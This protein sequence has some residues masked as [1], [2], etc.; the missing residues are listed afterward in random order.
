MESVTIKKGSLRFQN[1]LQQLQQVLLTAG[2]TANPALSVYQQKGRNILFMLEALGRIYQEIHNKKTFEKLTNKFKKLE[3]LLGEIDYYDSFYNQFSLVKSVPTPILE[4]IQT[5]RNAAIEKLNIRLAEKEWI[6][7]KQKQIQK[8]NAKLNSA[9]WLS[10]HDDTIAIKNLY[11]K[12]AHAGSNDYNEQKIDLTDIESG[13]HELRRKLRWL[14]IYPQATKGLFQ[15]TPTIPT[16]E[17]LQKYFTAETVTSPFN[18]M[19]P[20][21][22]ETIKLSKGYFLALSWLIAELGKLKD[23]GLKILLLKE[24]IMSIYHNDETQSLEMAYSFLGTHQ[25][26]LE[27]I[28]STAN[29]IIKTFFGERIPENLLDT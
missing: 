11:E 3:D 24:A 27:S 14:S 25:Q 29:N 17:Y 28:I 21:N 6:G 7:K 10:E 12:D 13:L 23:E 8:I 19:P 18:T 2:A 16:P 9:D 15:L 20:A 5:K 4:H 26:K 22:G 1:Y